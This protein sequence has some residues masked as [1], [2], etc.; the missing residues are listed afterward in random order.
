M[1][2]SSIDLSQN[3]SLNQIFLNNNYLTELDISN[4]TSLSI[5]LSCHFN[6]NNIDCIQLPESFPN[7]PIDGSLNYSLTDSSTSWEY[8]WF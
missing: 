7:P 5:G 6:N 1:F 4:N 2:L 3:L 8:D